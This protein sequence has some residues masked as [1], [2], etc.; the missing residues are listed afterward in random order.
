MRKLTIEEVNRSCEELRTWNRWGEDNEIG[1][2][3][4]VTPQRIVEAAKLVT[5]GETFALAIN[6]DRNGPQT[7]DLGRFNPV[8]AMLATGV[9]AVYGVQDEMNI[10]Y[11]D[12]IMSLPLH[13]ATHWDSLSHI[14]Y[15]SYMWNGRDASLVSAGGAQKNG[16]EKAKDKMVGRGVLLDVARHKGTEA[17]EDGYAIT[18]EDLDGCASEQNVEVRTG[19][20]LLVRTGQLGKCLRT[21]SWGNYAGGDAPGLAFETLRWLYDHEIAAVAS[22]TWG[23]E[24]R[25]NEIDEAFQPWHW[26]AIPNMGLSVGEMFYLEELAAGCADD[27]RYEFFFVAPPL[28]ITGAS[29]S[30]VNPMAIK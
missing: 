13:G 8:H 29:G 4:F 27:G 30:P 26:V 24:V 3:N 14:F 12:D 5:K 17:L 15:D 10:R 21:G 9:D 6:F 11:S 19:D 7:G 18:S 2:L 22:D 28:P 20:F 25:P 1:T 23:V 16:I